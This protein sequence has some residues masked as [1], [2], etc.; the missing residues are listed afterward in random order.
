MIHFQVKNKIIFLISILLDFFVDIK[1]IV[2]EDKY[3]FDDN[4]ARVQ[5][6]RANVA[7][8]RMSHYI[9]YIN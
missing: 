3:H 9:F 5:I 6:P 7:K 4:S 2:A 8:V 1:E